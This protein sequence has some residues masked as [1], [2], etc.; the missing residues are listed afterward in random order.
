MR[1]LGRDENAVRRKRAGGGPPNKSR[2][3]KT[4]GRGGHVRVY[5]CGAE[6]WLLGVFSAKRFLA[7]QASHSL[8]HLAVLTRSTGPVRAF[9]PL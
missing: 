2:V 4:E 6:R 1:S 3:E 9:F 8:L 7:W 5:S